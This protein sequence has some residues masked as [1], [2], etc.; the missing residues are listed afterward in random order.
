MAKKNKKKV[1]VYTILV[2]EGSS[3]KVAKFLDFV[4]NFLNMLGYKQGTYIVSAHTMNER[5]Y[6]KDLWK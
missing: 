3:K 4:M 1:T 6:L 5:E 2:E